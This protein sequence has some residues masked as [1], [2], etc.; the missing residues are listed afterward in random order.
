MAE[1]N[2]NGNLVGRHTKSGI[3]EVKQKINW[4]IENSNTPIWHIIR[5]I[6]WSF[7]SIFVIG[8]SLTYILGIILLLPGLLFKIDNSD[9]LIQIYCFVV[10]INGIIQH[11]NNMIYIKESTDMGFGIWDA[12]A[13]TIA[14]ILTVA[15]AMIS[16]SIH[17][18][19]TESIGLIWIPIA[20]IG[21]I[22]IVY[23]WKLFME[24]C[25]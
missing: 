12:I 21:V 25:I 7:G 4:N 19:L 17:C 16:I 22:L 2:E 6:I 1:I 24:E 18:K 23:I 13:S 14:S 10:L 8:F 20:I 5:H 11:L 9:L 3:K 15:A